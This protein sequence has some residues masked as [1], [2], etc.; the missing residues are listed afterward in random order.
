MGACLWWVVRELA[1]KLPND[2]I[3]V[4]L[5]VQDVFGSV[6]PLQLAAFA[7]AALACHLLLGLC[8]FGLARLS[9]AAFPNRDFARR[10]LLVAGWFM[11][12]AGLVMAANTTWNVSSIFA[13]EASLWRRE[14][15]GLWPV[16]YAFIAVAA[17]VAWM[18]VRAALVARIAFPTHAGI[19]T[20]VVLVLVLGTLAA[21]RLMRE[22]TAATA[23]GPPHVV[24]I[25][26][27]SLRSD[28]L[29]P[30]LGEASVPNIREFLARA[31][32]FSDATTPL[33]RTY[34][35]W[36]SVL[37]GRN[38]HTT[39][40]R[41]NLMPRRLVRE[42]ETLAGALRH[43]GYRSIYATDEVRFANFDE[44]YGFDHVVTPP[45]GAI[46]F[47]LG[48][49][50]DI[51]LVNLVALT[52]A[53]ARLFPSN[54]GNRAA[55]VTYEPGQF[56]RRLR[57]EIDIDGPTFLAIHLTLAHWPY[58]WSGM[59]V[60]TV[61]SAYRA[62]YGVAIEAVDQQFREVMQLLTNAGVLDNAIV[63]LLSDHGETLGGETDSM[64]RE[65][66]TAHEIWNSLWGHGTSVMSPNQYTVLLA[67]RGYGRA[68]APGTAAM[69]DFPV[70]LE[71]VRPTLEEYVTGN[72]P[73]NVDGLSLLPFLVDPGRAAELADRVRFTET[74]FNTP[75]TLAG[76]YEAS[77]I[78]DEA[79]VYYE[80]DPISGWVQL[81]EACLPEL[82]AKKQ[83]AAIS[84][85]GLLAYIP[86]H[87]GGPAK[88]L[89]TPRL[90]PQP[91]VLERRPDPAAQPEA[92]RLWDALH[93]RFAGE[94]AAPAGLP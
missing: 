82:I 41:Y 64:L 5:S 93:A 66:G 92:A 74:D 16:Q 49:G 22:S 86:N 35:S 1:L 75:S 63:V 76:R 79:A 58:A 33:A 68:A 31:A 7:A 67:M 36:L 13:G 23:H 87:T 21:P 15:F 94:L 52:S 38:P 39:N 10:G 9:E 45:V 3:T 53:G 12:L 55:Y 78:I 17:F 19:A 60:P 70:S 59:S 40:A 54:H 20:V 51:P 42:G 69:H 72:V 56:L 81:R 8:A 24:I 28:L 46:D 57:R 6:L 83:R 48:Y 25:G 91:Q 65:T 4:S 11:L 47:L 71:D 89:F 90:D 18:A 43:H 34:P 88:Y 37:T 77:G 50:G 32:R 29:L 80:L 14:I 26:I 61:P 2:R 85:G 44:S 30:R 27:D 84:A 62:A 73:A